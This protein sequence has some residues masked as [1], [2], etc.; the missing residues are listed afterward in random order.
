MAAA[1]SANYYCGKWH[2]GV[3][4]TA[5]DYGLKGWSLP[6]YGNLYDCDRYKSYLTQIKEPQPRCKIEH[7]LLDPTLSGTE[8]LMDPAE[9]WDY[10]D[11]AGVVLGSSEV[12]EQF[13]VAN[14]ACD[15]LNQLAD[16]APP[17]SMVVSMWGPHHTSS[18]RAEVAERA[19]PTECHQ[20]PNFARDLT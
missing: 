10:M 7:H 19:H 16:H 12:N 8:V 3:D 13:F 5:K 2:G 9:P 11:G 14:L 18:P 4:K 6:E 15:Q 1:G 17:F 20:C